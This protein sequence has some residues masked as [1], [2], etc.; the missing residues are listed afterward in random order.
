MPHVS[1]APITK[2]V[3][4]IIHGAIDAR[5]SDVHIEPQEPDMRVRYR[6]DGILH[7]AINVPS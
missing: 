7:D 3:S 4:S 2:L 5:A 1:D 6:I